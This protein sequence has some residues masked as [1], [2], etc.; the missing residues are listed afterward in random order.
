MRFIVLLGDGDETGSWDETLPVECESRE[1]L[2]QFI[3]HTV[4]LALA[5]REHMIEIFGAQYSRSAFYNFTTRAVQ[6]PEIYSLEEW[7]DN[8]VEVIK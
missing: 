7:F 3:R 8:N 2:E 4:E 5:N 6:M 1:R